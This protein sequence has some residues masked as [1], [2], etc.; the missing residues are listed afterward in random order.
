MHRLVQDTIRNSLSHSTDRFALVIALL[1]ASLPRQIAGAPENWPL[2]RLLLPHV[3]A[4]TARYDENSTAPADVAWL[5]EGAAAYITVVDGRPVDGLFLLKRAREIAEAAYG[6]DDPRVVSILRNLGEVMAGLGRGGEAQPLLER[7]LAIHERVY[8]PDHPEVAVDLRN[9][10]EVMAGLGRGGE[11]QPLLERALRVF[12]ATYGSD[13]PDTAATLSILAASPLGTRHAD[14]PTPEALETYPPRDTNVEEAVETA[15]PKVRRLYKL[16]DVFKKNGIP[17]V[18]FVEPP[19]FV[20][21]R[22]AL[23]TPGRGIVVEGPSGIGKTTFLRKAL[24]EGEAGGPRLRVLSG[25]ARRDLSS[26]EKLPQGHDGIVAVDDFHRL[27]LDLRVALV[28]YLKVLADEESNSRLILVGIPGTGQTLVDLG[29]DVVTRV[30]VFRLPPAD[31]E[32]ILQ[33]VTQGESALNIKFS[34]PNKIVSAAA[35][36]LLIAQMIC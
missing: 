10:G 35:G 25:R 36:S 1:R 30:D 15:Y 19:E 2:W 5:L 3:L 16:S 11:A 9:L 7:A 28:D 26:I 12:Q 27:P 18:T 8:G 32:L 22:A 14:I 4:A 20:R 31:D 34:D 29:F 33:M 23:R 17:T 21:F 24:E 13:H 6:D